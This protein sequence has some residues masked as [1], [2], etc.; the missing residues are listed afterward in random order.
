M[1]TR[2]TKSRSLLIEFNSHQVL[3][4][5][6][7]RR[8]S[9]PATVDFAAEFDRE[10]TA[11]LRHWIE[12]HKDARKRW[13]TAVAGFLGR[14][15][16]LQRESLSAT[17]LSDP[18]QLVA[19][20]RDRQHL[21]FSSSSAP[22]RH[23]NPE[24]W[25]FRALEA[26]TGEPLP[27]SGPARPAL[28][29]GIAHE[30]VHEIQQQLLDL[31]LMPQQVEPSFLPL[32]G[33]IYQMA[34]QRGTPGAPVVIGLRGDA[35]D[36]YILGKE[37]VHTPGPVNQGLHTLAQQVRKEF[38][39]DTDGEGLRRLW[40][41]DAEMRKRA[42]K[43][44]RNLGAELRT[45]INSYE[46]TTGQPAGEIYCAH[47]P[48]ALAWLGDALVQVLGHERL[49]VD[50]RAWMPTAGL[51]PAPDLPEL[52]PH[53]LG[54]LSLA[55]NL[56]EAVGSREELSFARSGSY[57]RPWHVDCRR[58]IEAPGPRFV[59]RNFPLAAAAAALMLFAC[60]LAAWQWYVSRALEA[61]AAFWREQ[62]SSNRRL[63]AEL[64][65]MLNELNAR[66]ARFNQAYALMR[67]PYQ[68]TEFL[69]D[70]GRTLPPRLRLDRIEANDA[71]VLLTGSLQEPAEEASR[72]LGRY[73]ET[74]RRTPRL[75]SLFTS[76]SA[77]S[78]QR[79][80]DT[81]ALTFE[82]TMKL[83]PPP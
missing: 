13:T 28:L 55:A 72:S 57:A 21:R 63:T 19:G 38:A 35:T 5:G 18:A 59:G 3:V 83:A 44:L 15:P 6:F 34:E 45:V 26:V 48:P 25:T 37:G 16:I 32:F 82:I 64:T 30:E 4:A 10:N 22:F 20:I 51:Q 65:V 14:Q 49:E 47:L 69:M 36:I 17:G 31:R 12:G 8:R 2:F 79:E 60:T 41:P 7:T 62:L 70:L 75:G 33:T 27:E 9:G 43:V 39:L 42:P 23:V 40:V 54:A 73:M 66:T 76:I 68:A 78:L 56:P 1:F 74:L 52:G 80:R 61:D 29:F 11:G 67:A 58:S 81:D 77:T 50:C 53:W 71:R 24:Q 46:M